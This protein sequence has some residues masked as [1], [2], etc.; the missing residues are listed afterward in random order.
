MAAQR[1]FKQ[2]R[3]NLGIG[4]ADKMIALIR[5]PLAQ[6]RIVFDDAVM[7]HGDFFRLGKMRVA[8][9]IRRLAVGRPAGVAGTDMPGQRMFFELFAQRLQASLRLDHVDLSVFQHRDARGVISSVFQSCQAVHQDLRDV[10]ASNISDNTAHLAY[11]ASLLF[12]RVVVSYN[13]L[14]FPF[15][16]KTIEILERFC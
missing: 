5:Q 13:S 4:L 6:G 1:L 9:F 11:Q 7:H 12:E 14:S 10:F 15:S 16:P 2:L 8:V 3:K